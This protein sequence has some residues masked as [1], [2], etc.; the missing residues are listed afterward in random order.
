MTG[1][2]F[3][4][5]NELAA[6][7]RLLQDPGNRLV[8]V[9]GPPGVGKTALVRAATGDRPGTVFVVLADYPDPDYPDPDCPEPAELGSGAAQ[10]VLD[11]CE[12]LRA[13]RNL[14]ARLHASHPE[15]TVIVTGRRRLMLPGE[16]RLVLAPLAVPAAEAPPGQLLASPAV[17][18]FVER[19]HAIRP[20]LDLRPA[21]L[22]IIRRLVELTDGLPLALEFAAGWAGVMPPA[23]FVSWV[24]TSDPAT[25]LALLRDPAG[26]DQLRPSLSV[27]FDRAYRA[28]TEDERAF[29]A[30]LSVFESPADLAAIADICL[31]TTEDRVLPALHAGTG[32]QAA[33]D[34]LASLAEHSLLVPV[35][36]HGSQARMRLLSTTRSFARARLIEQGTEAVL[37]A[38]HAAYFHQRARR[39]AL[40]LN[41]AAHG[42]ALTEIELER[43]NL[44]AAVAWSRDNEPGCGTAVGILAAMWQFWYFVGDLDEAMRQFELVLTAVGSEPD[45]PPENYG[46]ILLAAGVL[47]QLRGDN[48]LAAEYLTQVLRA[49]AARADPGR[50]AVAVT[51][52]AIIAR[53]EGAADTRAALA[54]NIEYLRRAGNDDGLAFALAVHAEG[55]TGGESA[56]RRAKSEL[57]ESVDIF[58]R[59]Q[60]RWGMAFAIRVL[61]DIAYRERELDSARELLERSIELFRID[62]ATRSVIGALEMLATVAAAQGDAETVNRAESERADL[63]RT[64]D[65]ELESSPPFRRRGARPAGGSLSTVLSAAVQAAPSPHEAN[66][67]IASS[68]ITAREIDVLKLLAQARTNAE[69]AAELG[70]GIETVRRHVSNLLMKIGVRSRVEAALYAVRNGM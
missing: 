45:A 52:L 20:D 41:T 5:E 7:R 27:A 24:T 54:A 13:G 17:R 51:Q 37:L 25:A 8:S 6:L 69:I 70:I 9:T 14:V 21:G 46:D 57:A 60:N 34:L 12:D 22:A 64:L 16:R 49:P 10:M 19:A 63:C 18:L 61:A 15:L 40:R 55:L 65:I 39:V 35:D 68:G 67:H 36:Q 26:R 48:R 2:L 11:G 43:G 28:L 62:C 38:R 1:E 23:A 56:D 53:A 31:P 29:L 59:R 4:R 58:E 33:L 44:L 50:R 30:R 42:S 47:A 66:P 32:V 3:G